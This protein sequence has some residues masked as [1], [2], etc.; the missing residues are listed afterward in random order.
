MYKIILK[1]K[2]AMSTG[3]SVYRHAATLSTNQCHDVKMLFK[4][5]V[6]VLAKILVRH[7]EVYLFFLSNKLFIG[8]TYPKNK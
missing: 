5:S 1:T 4:S 7:P 3:P 6:A 2:S 8:S